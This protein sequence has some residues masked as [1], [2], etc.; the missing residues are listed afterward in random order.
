MNP[1]LPYVH[2]G[3]ESSLVVMPFLGTFL[4]YY[5]SHSLRCI[6]CTRASFPCPNSAATDH[7]RTMRSRSSPSSAARGDATRRVP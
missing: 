4:L 7:P 2:H 6:C 5:S 1:H 3:V